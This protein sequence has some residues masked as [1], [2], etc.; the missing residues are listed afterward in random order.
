MR[1]TRTPVGVCMDLLHSVMVQTCG[2]RY[3]PSQRR[4]RVQN[5]GRAYGAYDAGHFPTSKKL[6]ESRFLFGVSAASIVFHA[7]HGGRASGSDRLTARQKQRQT[8]QRRAAVRRPGQNHSPTAHI[9]HILTSGPTHIDPTSSSGVASHI[10][11]R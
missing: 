9:E 3:F 11:S 7:H 2:C 5:L 6:K 10:I 1:R 4:T 8:E